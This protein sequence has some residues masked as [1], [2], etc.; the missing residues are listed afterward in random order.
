MSN[1]PGPYA[2]DDVR[3][4]MSP[5]AVVTPKPVTG[6]FYQELDAEF[7]GFKGHLLVQSGEFSEPWPT[8]EIHPHGDEL[9]YLL[10]G[11]ADFVLWV[12]GEEQVVRLGT[13]GELVIVP[14]N[15]WHTARPHVATKLLFITPGE[16]TLNEERPSPG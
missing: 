7:S 16:G 13:P 15:T 4:I 11:D 9:V 1:N 8:W 6:T 5:D 2:L 3:M 14:R 10:Y 12:D